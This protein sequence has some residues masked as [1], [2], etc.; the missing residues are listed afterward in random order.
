MEMDWQAAASEAATYVSRNLMAAHRGA[1]PWRHLGIAVVF[2]N[3]GYSCEDDSRPREEVDSVRGRLRERGIEELGFG[4]NAGDGYSWAML[5]RSD[6]VEYLH[7][8]VWR[9]WPNANSVQYEIALRE[10]AAHGMT[11]QASLN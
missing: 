10:V 7:D 3:D 2:G 8:A 11:P 6:D 5:V 1:M 4:L 9:S